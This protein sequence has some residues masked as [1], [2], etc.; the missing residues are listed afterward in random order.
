MQTLADLMNGIQGI[1]AKAAEMTERTKALQPKVDEAF[2]AVIAAEAKDDHESKTLEGAAIG[3]LIERHVRKYRGSPG[4][5]SIFIDLVK[6]SIS[7][8]LE[9]DDQS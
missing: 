8:G 4:Y 2:D 6:E 5:L 3:N 9:D 7:E 1:M